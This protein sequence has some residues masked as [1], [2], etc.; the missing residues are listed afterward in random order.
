MQK[1]PTIFKRDYSHTYRV[2]KEINPECQWVFDGDG[3]A[4]RKYQGMA[5]MIKDGLY[6]KRIIIKK[7]QLIPEN[8]ILVTQD[9][10]SKKQFGWL[11]VDF[12]HPQDQYYAKAYNPN[13]LDGTY[14]LIGPHI[15]NNYEKVTND[16]LVRHDFYPII[17]LKRNY[18]TIRK[19]LKRV[20][21]EGIVF[22]HC[23]GRMAKIKKK[24]FGYV[25]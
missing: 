1:I 3:V 5:A 10:Q 20:D 23:D 24:D 19:Y 9:Q 2:T 16:Q 4:Y 13:Y 22:H 6:Y 7:D 15:L 25:R 8:F 18:T 11:P 17:P 14:E 12:E 21:F